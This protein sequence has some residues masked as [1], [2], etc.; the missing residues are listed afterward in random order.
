LIEH[1]HFPDLETSIHAPDTVVVA[2]YSPAV[3]ISV[4]EQL[5]IRPGTDLSGLI[6]AVLR[7]YGFDFVF[8]SSFG[9]EL[10]MVEQAKIYEERK[11]EGRDFPLITSSCPAWVH[12]MEQYYPEFLPELS[13][14]KSPHQLAGTLIRE[15]LPAQL[16]PE[17]KEIVSVV[18]SS[19]TAAKTEAKRVE[20]TRD[21]IPVIDLVLTTRELARMIKLS[22][23]DLEQL[24]PELPDTPFC[25]PGS[26]GK[27][28]AVAGGE[29]EATVRTIYHQATGKE[30]TPSRLHR[31]RIHKSFRE[32]AV[33][34]G[35]SEIRMGT[36]SGLARAV[37]L[38]EE[39][40]SGKR[41]LDLLEVMAC[42][43][44]CVNGGGQPIPVDE[45][46]LR[47]RTKAI[48][49]LDN[50]SS[51]CTAHANPFLKEFYKNGMGELGTGA[52][53]DLLHTTFTKREVLL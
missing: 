28:S 12:Y 33:K 42:P 45:Q 22:G 4:A 53:K 20:M 16:E 37:T 36:V 14:L 25:S 34:T 13:P 27:L 43:G 44:G 39:I 6:C 31:F 29:V 21:G 52:S 32:M 8:E 11:K 23:L 18:I 19:C 3:T 40:K 47:T 30:L 9:A 41:K 1:V 38:M 49:D 10:M 15:W 5:G 50:G 51:I 24:E 17:K 2:Q 26:A 35:N 46:V 7:R 48:Y